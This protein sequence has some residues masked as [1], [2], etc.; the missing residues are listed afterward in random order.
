MERLIPN[1][2]PTTL[3]AELDGLGLASQATGERPYLVTN[4]VLSLDG[5]A[6]LEGRSGPLGSDVD[7]DLLVGLRRRADALMIGAGTMRV[8]RYGPTGGLTVLVSG[9][10]DLP[11]DAPLFTEGRGRCLVFTASDRDP[12]PTVTPVEVVCHEG[13]VDLVAALCHLRAEHDVGVLLCEGGPH[14]HAELIEAGLVDELFVTL[15]PKL[16]GGE[17][18]HLVAGLAEAER[19]VELASLLHEP[20][21]GE[22]FARYRVA[23]TGP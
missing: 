10:L 2:G 3:D 12:P 14:L 22:L 15:A 4:F 21:T 11:W 8:E 18:P 7:T 13:R 6:T 9:R 23:S 5:R 17:G 20:A 19:P 16:A 1:P